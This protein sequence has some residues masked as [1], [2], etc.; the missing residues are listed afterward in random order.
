MIEKSLRSELF[1]DEHNFIE[2]M[3][4]LR[5]SRGWSQTELARMMAGMG[6]DNYTQMTV[7]R[8]E[9]HERPLRLSEAVAICAVLSTDM[10]RMTAP[11][12]QLTV[13]QHLEIGL[14]E[15]QK[16]KER[17]GSVL[18]RIQRQQSELHGYIRA[19]RSSADRDLQTGSLGWE[20]EK[21]ADAAEDA[22]KWAA[23]TEAL[24]EV[25]DLGEHSEEA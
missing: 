8:T 24:K 13:V 3:K 9:K 12:S 23:T 22:L 2:N 19:F 21:L 6:W 1:E 10:R 15:L 11:P 5:E 14:K 17:L 25:I 7:S 18:R 16:S 4:S 20:I